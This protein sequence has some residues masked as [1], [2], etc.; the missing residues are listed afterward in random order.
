MKKL[1]IILLII[2]PAAAYADGLITDTPKKVREYENFYIKVKAMKSFTLI[3][4][5]SCL[6]ISGTEGIKKNGDVYSSKENGKITFDNFCFEKE[7]I[8]IEIRSNGKSDILRYRIAPK[9]ET[10]P[11]YS[12]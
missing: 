9:E 8:K 7:R 11:D 3:I 2:A 4:N 1:L 12:C 6:K 5:K 10:E